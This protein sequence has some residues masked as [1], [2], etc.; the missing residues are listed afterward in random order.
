MKHAY[1]R[2][3][4]L[5]VGLCLTI[6]ASMAQSNPTPWLLS[7]GNYALAAWPAAS[8][9]TTFPP[10][11]VYHTFTE[12]IEPFAGALTQAP[13]GDWLLAW[14]LTSGPRFNG[15]DA[16]GVEF[17]Q[18][19]TAQAANCSFVG[20]A[21]L[22]VNTTGQ[23]NVKLTF[24][25]KTVSVQ[26]RPYVLRL[27]YRTSTAATWTDAFGAD[28]GRVEHRSSIGTAITAYTFVLPSALENIPLVQFRWLYFQDGAGSGNRP[29]IQ[30]DEIAV[31]ST[32]IAGT[33]TNV[34]VTAMYPISPS[35][36]TP[37]S[38]TVRSTD[39]TGAPKNVASA[40][41]VTLTKTTGTGTLS[42]TLSG[43]I[44]AGTSIV[45]LTNVIYNVAESGVGINAAVT[46]GPALTSFNTPTFTVGSAASYAVVNGAQT[47]CY[48]GVVLNPFT[49][50][51]FRTDNTIDVNYGATI[52]LTKTAG[53]GTLSGVTSVIPYR[54]VATFDNVSLST[55]GSVTLQLTIP[56]LTTQTLPLTTVLSTP[57]VTTNI[58]PQYIT[59]RFPAAAACSFDNRPLPSYSHVTFT[60]L[61]PNTTY[62]YN[63]GG[64]ENQPLTSTGGGFNIHYNAGTNTYVYS[65]AKN[66]VNPGEYS[67]FST[68]NGE[69][70]KSLWLNLVPTNANA[71][72]EGGTVYWR[73]ALGNAMGA[74]IN[75][76]QLSQTSIGMD[77]AAASNKS[78]LLGERSSDMTALNYVL[79]Y[80]NTAGTGRPL[81]VS[82]V[83][84]Y[85]TAVTGVT[86]RYSADIEGRAGA[87]MV[88]IP[89]ALSTGVRR[90]EL[91]NYATNAIVSAVTSTDGNWN[92]TSTYPMNA[93]A[94]P[95]GPGGFATP[96]YIETPRVTVSQPAKGDTV[97]SGS[98]VNIQFRA[99]G[100]D[101]VKIEYSSNNGLSWDLIATDVAV[102][103]AL[104]T[105]STGTYQWS[106]PG[107]GLNPTN[108]IVRVTG[109]DRPDVNGISGVF[110][111]VEPL[112]IVLDIV[113]KNLCLD[114][115]DTMLIITSGS[116]RGYQWY[117]D[118]L[119][120]A[121]SNGPVLYI[122]DAHYNTAGVYRCKVIGY[123]G[124]GDVM[125]G[126]ASIR[127]AR[128]TQIVT[129]SFAV[130]G[131]LGE[132]AR[133]WVD[134]EFPN[135][136][137]SY[138]WYRDQTPLTDNGNYY[139]SQSN[140]L[141][142]RN[143]VQSNYGNDYYCVVTGVC[144]VAQSRVVRVF[145]T[146]VYAEFQVP[147]VNACTDGN[148]TLNADVYSNPAGETLVTRWYRNGQPLVEGVKYSGT[149]TSD[150]T[151]NNVTPAEAGEYVIKTA[152]A[153]DPTAQAEASVN[154]MIATTPVIS[155]Q[156]ANADV[157][158]GQGASIGLTADAQGTIMYQWLKDDVAIDGA[159]DAFYTIAQ[160]TATRAGSYTCRVTT[161]C[162]TVTSD[163]AILTIKPATAITT[164]PEPTIALN[165]GQTLTIAIV[166][167]GAGTVQYQWYKDGTELTG[168]V[169]ATYTKVAATTDAGSYWCRVLS[170]CGELFSDT[171]V[172]TVQPVSGVDDLVFA[173][174]V[175]VSHVMPNPANTRA[176]ISVTL[177]TENVVTLTLVDASG[178]V[179]FELV[180]GT[181]NAGTYSLEIGTSTISNGVYALRTS[182][183]GNSNVQTVVVVK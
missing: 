107:V 167:T 69:T 84:S 78:T 61:Q 1:L 131:V 28:G 105:P 152:L 63:V 49:V 134:A 121:N 91:R 46:G 128:K 10:S 137:I 43:T 127:V 114:D 80:D 141:E 133:L 65:A 22:A 15:R 20:E 159:T 21:I 31:V 126:Q 111:V 169:A 90:I 162:G 17:T 132:T 118:G 171:S 156:P 73:V 67:T 139:G 5:G 117:K 16:A 106:V 41:T 18:T 110:S 13:N 12:R 74:L 35:V 100:M 94:Y 125:S 24:N 75:Y 27:Q 177:P 175:S 83:Q 33:P 19:G 183:G 45:T 53:G 37:F 86:A 157:C 153:V 3:A 180:T 29:S 143:F 170:E 40:T 116:I 25:A 62:R 165:S 76:Y 166:A 60:N 124:C 146:G 174:G 58:V 85:N 54:G 164:Q 101:S 88:Q 66:L 104:G 103:G 151:I 99:E 181:L 59:S 96:I 50:T 64:I 130:P 93:V 51:I 39:A 120:I 47:Q 71:F 155:R 55:A 138:Q 109:V 9:A 147:I 8:P 14:N 42:G 56:G 89:N 79:V 30:L 34:W 70:T 145:P 113:S 2:S 48:A 179:V 168:E 32:P 44:A 87:W 38:V 122:T 115:N 140:K 161:A 144:G 102:F 149:T 158:E 150:L 23:A 26:P 4:I 97:C 36:N 7:S 57:S 135:E 173:N 148:V 142:I 52:T 95:G 72:A 108:F 119:P 112:N 6:V 172:V 160:A 154:V 92:G 178:T 81:G 11:M 136:V 123:G 82:I 163:A 129:Q 98:M 182:V 176:S 77:N 68:G